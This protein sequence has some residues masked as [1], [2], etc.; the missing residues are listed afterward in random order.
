M[1][2]A[3]NLK[4][5][6][7]GIPA[8]KSANDSC[9]SSAHPTVLIATI[10]PQ[11]QSGLNGILEATAVNAIWVNSV[12]SVKLVIRKEKIAACF[13]GFWL[14][15]GTYREVIRYLRR[16]QIELPAVLLSPPAYPHDYGQ[17][18]AAMNL[19][20]LDFLCYPYQRL[21]FEKLIDSAL[22]IH[23]YSIETDRSRTLSHAEE[24]GAV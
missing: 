14:L 19:G 20:G 2:P 6:F 3:I 23:S 16:G 9:R 10:D 15:D 12:E 24:R 11:I 5:S 21:E 18:L 13:C 1:N 7:E 17:Y 4:A 22:N 8:R